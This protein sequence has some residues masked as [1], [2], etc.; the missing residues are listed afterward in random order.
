MLTPGGAPTRRCG[1]SVAFVLYY[2]YIGDVAHRQ[3]DGIASAHAQRGQGWAQG[4]SDLVREKRF[5]PET[6]IRHLGTCII[7][8]DR[9]IGTKLPRSLQVEMISR[10]QIALITT[11]TGVS[12]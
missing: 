10:D 3:S 9:S 6:N 12:G 8:T 2:P 4:D 7:A 1:T 11:S 5:S